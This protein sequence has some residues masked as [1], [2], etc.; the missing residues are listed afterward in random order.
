MEEPLQLLP[1]EL[2]VR[3]GKIEYAG[4]AK[5]PDKPFDR[6]I[7]AAGDLLMPGFK[8]AHT[9]SPMTFLRSLADDLPLDQWLQEQVFPMEAKLTPAD[10]GPLTRLAILEYL[11]SGITA[12]F[13]MYMFPKEVAETCRSEE[14][15][16]ELQSP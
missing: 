3:D 7:D 8:N 15:T 10:I 1:G 11:T 14:H 6:T 12:A 2:W 16:S 4:P 9:H 5:T 13:D